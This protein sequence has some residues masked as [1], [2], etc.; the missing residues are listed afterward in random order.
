MDQ[1]G[2]TESNRSN[3]LNKHQFKS[4]DANQGDTQTQV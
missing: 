3:A 4:S 2:K 1:T